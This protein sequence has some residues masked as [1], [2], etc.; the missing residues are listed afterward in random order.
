MSARVAIRTAVGALLI[1]L[2][3]SA[4]GLAVNALRPAGIPLVAP[5]PYQQDCPD[6]VA[7]PAGPTVSGAQARAL[8][9]AGRALLVDA[10]PADAFAAEHAPGA[11][12]LPFSFIAPPAADRLA[13]LRGHG[14][15]LVYD[16]SPGDKLAGL[17]AAQLRESGLGDVKV[18]SGG[19]AAYRAAPRGAK[20]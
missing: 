3:G 20:P 7:V 9:R 8:V 2:C 12:S 15:L 13:T 14:A 18:L 11:V 4:L 16:D 6:K 1:T 5:F 19:L 10:R 17:L